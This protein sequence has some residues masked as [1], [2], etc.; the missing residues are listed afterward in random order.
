MTVRFTRRGILALSGAALVAGCGNNYS[1]PY[2]SPEVVA[3]SAYVHPG[4]PELTLYTMV[5]NRTGEGSHSALMINASQRVIFDPAGTAYFRT[6]P[7]LNDVLYGITP[8][9]EQAFISAHA[10]RTFHVRL[11]RV[12]VSPEIAEVV[13]RRAQARG[14]VAATACASSLT[15]ILQGLPGFEPI[16]STMW[17]NRLAG[18]FARLPLTEDRRIYEDDEDDKTLAIAILEGRAPR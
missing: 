1:G 6:L 17:P 12:R 16:R 8:A 18:Q 4:P 3:R 14:P 13:L 9:A 2:A 10:R 15:D 5:N 11:Q 7:E